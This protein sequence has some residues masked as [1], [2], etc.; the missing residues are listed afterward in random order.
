MS[1]VDAWRAGAEPADAAVSLQR[2]GEVVMAPS[3]NANAKARWF[4]VVVALAVASIIALVLLASSTSAADRRGED[5]RRA[6]RRDEAGAPR[7]DR[8]F[9]SATADRL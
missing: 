3:P 4:A 5:S 6:D 9:L 8:P 1:S 7:L 2:S